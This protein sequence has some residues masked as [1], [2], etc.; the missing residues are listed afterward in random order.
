MLLASD[1]GD[2]SH[3]S[4]HANDPFDL[5]R[6]LDAQEARYQHALAELRAGQKRSHWSW[7][8]LPQVLGLGFSSMSVR[9]AIGSLAEA[10][11]YLEHPVLGTRLRECVA[12]MNAHTGLSAVHILGQVDAQ[13]FRSCLTLFAQAASSDPLFGDALT[14]YF[15]GQPDATTLAI[16]ARQ[17]AARGEAHPTGSGL[18]G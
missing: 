3:M 13:K 11:A 6:F 4:N 8:I 12:A 10:K 16:L 2:Y 9:Y 7:Y 1:T 5:Q 15:A 18:G 14:K 17:H